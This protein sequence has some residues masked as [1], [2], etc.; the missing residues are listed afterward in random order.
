LR[1]FG[2]A[3]LGVPVIAGVYVQSA[4]RRSSILRLAVLAAVAALLVGSISV[5][6]R[7]S[8]TSGRPP[9]SVAP[10]PPT[11]FT[12]R[13]RTGVGLRDEVDMLF[14]EQMDRA[15]VA[16]AL[17]LSP[18]VP[19][20]LAWRDGDRT[21]AV[22]PVGHWQA[23]TFYTLTVAP[24][25]AAR[26]G[27]PLGAP[28]RAPFATRSA[29]VVSLAP[30]SA[31]GGGPLEPVVLVRSTV[32]L[33]PAAVRSALH[34]RP[35]APV[36]VAVVGDPPG[37][38]T[39][40]E[41]R[42]LAPLAAGTRY[43]LT[44]E[45]LVDA[46]GAL[47]TAPT[48]FRLRT[49]AAPAVVRFR[50]TDGSRRIARDAELSVRFTARMNRT[51]TAAAFSA[52]VGGK[53][54]SLSKVRWA[55]GRTVLV[56]TPTHRLGWGARV[57]LSVAASATSAIGIPL[58]SA[59]GATFRV[60]AK[61]KPQAKTSGGGGGGGGGSGGGG[62]GA[63]GGSGGGGGGS[64]GSSGGSAT[65]Y[66]VE[67]YYLGL[68]NC[69]RTGGWVTSTGS[70]SSPGGRSVAPLLLSAGISSHVSRPYARYLAVHNACDHFLDGN[71][72]DRLRRAGYTSY[73]WGENIGCR[74]GNPYDAVLASHLFFQDE[75]PTNGGHYVN[76]MNALYD[77]CGI[78][79]W[80][81]AGRVRLVVDLYHP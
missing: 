69:T 26:S 6:M 37:A 75:K 56:A 72:G 58:G 41:I 55:E 2:V 10:L 25:A 43:T 60:A 34:V 78:G 42:S 4:L 79:V 5:A 17:S 68:M 50:P 3:L 7:P 8:P 67:K 74:S 30:G 18:S 63:G 70:C 52:T 66:A 28:A 45:G 12:A 33:D 21:L 77:R 44:L 46:D 13:L 48:P 16:A 40:F 39:A 80:V 76:L 22:T 81:Y 65:W 49:T 36:A 24:D 23:G 27:R 1:R 38:A 11:A 61:P 15:S 47:A 62:S 20:R 9:L 57:H 53:P 32:P 19:V 54:L 51:T 14:S 73:K 29:A 71:P 35:A 64:G 59:D 31:A